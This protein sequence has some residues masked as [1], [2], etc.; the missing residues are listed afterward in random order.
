MGVAFAARCAEVMGD[1]TTATREV[2]LGHE[3]HQAPEASGLHHLHSF[4][5]L[6]SQ[7]PLLLLGLVYS[8]H[9]W[10]GWC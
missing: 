3:H 9:Y 7:A 10:Q 2:H 5:N 6:R 4:W 1:T 8:T